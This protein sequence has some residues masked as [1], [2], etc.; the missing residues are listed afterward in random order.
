MNE[1][2]KAGSHI[3]AGDGGYGIGTKENYDAF[4]KVRNKSL[5]AARI[6]RLAEQAGFDVYGWNENELEKFA[7][8]IINECAEF[9]ENDDYRGITL[10]GRLKQHFGVG[11]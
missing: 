1:R 9:V 7:E 6:R 11:E 4:V 3:H 5:A 8:L 2:I 10:A